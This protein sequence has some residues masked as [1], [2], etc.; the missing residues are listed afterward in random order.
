MADQ[1]PHSRRLAEHRAVWDVPRLQR[2][3]CVRCT[4]STIQTYEPVQ[5]IVQP[6]IALRFTPGQTTQHMRRY[7]ARLAP[8]A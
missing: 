6:L 5:Q 2:V 3:A 8:G 7:R 4:H 1:L